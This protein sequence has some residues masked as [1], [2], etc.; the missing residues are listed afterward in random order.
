MASTRQP[1]E[2][3]T[4]TNFGG[5]FRF[6]PR[7]AYTPSSET[8][9]LEILRHHRDENIRAVG[10]L[11]SWSEVAKTEA[12]L[13]SLAHFTEIELDDQD[14]GLMITVGAGCTLREIL[15]RLRTLA[16]EWTLPTLGAVTQQTIA[17][18]IA[19][20][21]HGSG[22]SSL[23]HY[24]E[25]VRIAT[26][27]PETGEP[28]IVT[29]NS[30]AELRAA[31]C[32]LG[33]LGI[34]LSVR[35]RCVP[36]YTI[37]ETVK[38]YD[39]IGE[40]LD[41]TE[42]YPWQQI[43]LIPGRW[44]YVGFHRSLDA[45]KFGFPRNYIFPVR[46]WCQRWVLWFWQ[47][48]LFH[49]QV[50]ARANRQTNRQW[51]EPFYRRFENSVRLLWGF[52]RTGR[53][54]GM[55]TFD[56]HVVPHLNVELFVP[57][58]HLPAAAEFV[59]TAFRLFSGEETTVPAWMQQLLR[60]HDLPEIEDAIGFY[61]LH[62]P[63]AFRRVLADDTLISPASGS[64]PAWYSLGFFTYEEPEKQGRYSQVARYL[65]LCLHTL[66]SARLHWGKYFPLGNEEIEAAYP[67]LPQFRQICRRYDP[68]GVFLNPFTAQTLGF[69]AASSED[70]LAT[71]VFGKAN[72]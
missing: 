29:W 20:G 57:E 39:S 42:K 31:R 1:I 5:N 70:A 44:K 8:E 72:T 51:I 26:F 40:V 4:Y 58:R 66:F 53:S 41:Q 56:H 3:A 27:D 38:L 28:T 33:C 10:S 24:V 60:A 32:S 43:L 55:L 16:P 14:D 49:W 19:T 46:C 13:V 22:R 54:D 11:Y 37:T 59:Q 30:G 21:T 50:R 9:V 35:L 25:E 18:A 67:Q 7:C 36:Q 15:A 17:G 52:P 34:V 61:A 45:P 2:Q 47:D 71:P 23:S 64:E 63:L 12:V 69:S 62:Y 65:A 68:R 48:R 6:T